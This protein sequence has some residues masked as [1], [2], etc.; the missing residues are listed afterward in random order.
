MDELLL[1]DGSLLLLER[2][3]DGTQGI[4]LEQYVPPVVNLTVDVEV[5]GV[6]SSDLR[7]NTPKNLTVDIVVDAEVGV[8]P[9]YS[10]APARF[11]TVDVVVDGELTIGGLD[12]ETPNYVIPRRPLIWVHG[13]A[14]E[15]RNVI[16]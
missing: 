7:V 2:D 14:G 12:T 8:D 5:D 11:L 15:R 9:I 10:G 4:F 3:T 13:Y 1:E 6:V 16:D